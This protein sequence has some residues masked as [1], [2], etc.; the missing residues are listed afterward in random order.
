MRWLF[1]T[2]GDQLMEDSMETFRLMQNDRQ[3]T[4]GL[5]TIKV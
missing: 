5:F 1:R 2:V 3:K 4:I